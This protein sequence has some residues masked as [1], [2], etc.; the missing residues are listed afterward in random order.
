MRSRRALI[1]QNST[2][3]HPPARN[4]IP[5]SLR[6][7]DF[8]ELRNGAF[9]ATV[10]SSEDELELAGLPACYTRSTV[11]E[12]MTRYETTG[13]YFYLLNGG[14]AV[15]FLHGASVGPF[16]H[17]VQAEIIAG[18]RALV[19]GGFGAGVH[20]VSA[21]A[22]GSIATTWLHYFNER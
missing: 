3:E 8:P 4:P 16:I 21:A 22:R 7:E 11:A 12:H 2:Q 6:G 18:V 5:L 10:T 20:E 1:G 15:N 13:H 19:Q 9:V 14:E 17:L